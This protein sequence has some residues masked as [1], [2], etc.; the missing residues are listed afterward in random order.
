MAHKPLINGTLY[1]LDKGRSLVDG[2]IREID[3]GKTLVG[4]TV[5][6]VGFAKPVTITLAGSLSEGSVG[7]PGNHVEY[8]GNKYSSPCTFEAAVGDTITVYCGTVPSSA[9]IYLN[10]QQVASTLG[11]VTYS[12]T[13]TCNAIIE[14]ELKGSGMGGSAHMYITEIPEGHVLVNIS[15]ASSYAYAS[16]DGISYTTSPVTMTVTKGSTIT[17]VLDYD[18]TKY[19]GDLQI[20]NGVTDRLEG[21]LKAAVLLEL[22]VRLLAKVP[23]FHVQEVSGFPTAV[24]AGVNSTVSPG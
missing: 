23:G 22:I 24:T 17:L 1:E 16:I 18:K 6:E 5:Y 4:G 11:S 10:G 21:M 2:T 12:Y 19:Q 7:S 3:H 20:A 8:N 15:L 14:G 13:V 9:N